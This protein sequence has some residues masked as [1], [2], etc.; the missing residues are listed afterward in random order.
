MRNKKIE[1]KK[2]EKNLSINWNLAT[3]KD[4]EKI[5]KNNDGFIDGDKKTI[6]IK[7]KIKR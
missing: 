5:L 3:I 1:I 2:K 7:P 4:M 6:E